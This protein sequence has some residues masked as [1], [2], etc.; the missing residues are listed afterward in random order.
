MSVLFKESLH[1][2]FEI[3]LGHF[4]MFRLEMFLP[5]LKLDTFLGANV[6]ID[7]GGIWFVNKNSCLDNTEHERESDSMLAGH[8]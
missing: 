4:V 5:M 3:A 6:G 7:E 2:F 1:V 8:V